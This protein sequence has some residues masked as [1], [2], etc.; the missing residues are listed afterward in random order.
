MTPLAR[1]LL[2]ASKRAAP[3][4]AKAVTPDEPNHPWW[5]WVLLGFVL[6]VVPVLFGVYHGLRG[7]R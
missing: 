7:L 4:K 3:A 2:L 5:F 1:S 6:G